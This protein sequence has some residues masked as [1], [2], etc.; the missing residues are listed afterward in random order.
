M[1]LTHC[2]LR[3][4]VARSTIRALHILHSVTPADDLDAVGLAEALEVVVMAALERARAE[5]K[6][7]GEDE[8]YIAGDT[9][10]TPRR[11]V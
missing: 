11:S 7:T 4:Y 2:T 6:V 10:D 1:P 8:A 5:G 3:L 9:Q